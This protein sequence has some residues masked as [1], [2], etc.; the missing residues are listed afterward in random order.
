M[1]WGPLREKEEIETSKNRMTGE[2]PSGRANA[3]QNNENIHSLQY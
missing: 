1:F 3:F 2:S